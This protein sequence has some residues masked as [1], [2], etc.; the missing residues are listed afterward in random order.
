MSSFHCEKS[1]F[2]NMKGSLHGIECVQYM[3][4]CEY[5]ERVKSMCMNVCWI[6]GAKMTQVH[7]MVV[8]M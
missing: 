3:Y 7:W 8:I 2:Y 6:D 4:V 1:F 5:N